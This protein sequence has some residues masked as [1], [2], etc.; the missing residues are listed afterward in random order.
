[1]YGGYLALWGWGCSTDQVSSIDLVR[2]PDLHLR[3]PHDF[4]MASELDSWPRVQLASITC[5][6]IGA[7]GFTWRPL[8]LVSRGL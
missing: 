6:G 4:D 7:A 5:K 1:V 2:V 8:I 3:S